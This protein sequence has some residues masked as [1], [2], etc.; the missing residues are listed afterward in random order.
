MNDGDWKMYDARILNNPARSDAL[1]AQW[2]IARTHGG[3]APSVG[4]IKV[5]ADTEMHS[6]PMRAFVACTAS[7]IP[8]PG[9]ANMAWRATVANARVRALTAIAGPQTLRPIRCMGITVRKPWAFQAWYEKHV[10]A[11]IRAGFAPMPASTPWVPLVA[12]NRAP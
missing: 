9:P 6:A 2:H 10:R 7:D 3:A 8:L 4:K 5:Y 1:Y 12:S 11:Q